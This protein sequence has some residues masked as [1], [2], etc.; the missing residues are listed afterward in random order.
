MT[1]NWKNF[2]IKK[3][4][5]HWKKKK[6]IGSLSRTSFQSISMSIIHHIKSENCCLSVTAA[7][8]GY[9]TETY[10]WSLQNK[11]LNTPVAKLIKKLFH[12]YYAFKL[13]ND[14]NYQAFFR[15]KSL[16]YPIFQKFLP[17]FI[18]LIGVLWPVCADLIDFFRLSGTK[19]TTCSRMPLLPNVFKSCNPVKPSE[20]T[21]Q[22][23]EYIQFSGFESKYAGLV[24]RRWNQIKAA[25]MLRIYSLIPY[26]LLCFLICHSLIPTP[27]LGIRRQAKRFW[28]V[29]LMQWSHYM[30]AKALNFNRISS[31]VRQVVAS[32]AMRAL[33]CQL[34]TCCQCC[35][36]YRNS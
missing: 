7:C 18:L 10:S 27:V 6:K 32:G 19:M 36:F 12:H 30:K 2:N 35:L 23:N 29:I 33:L 13:D 26:D 22:I 21:Y 8:I 1:L 34:L 16:P 28:P 5:F 9:N 25:P 17:F 3:P 31:G 24:F 14:Y 11:Y 15:L 20:K 4:F